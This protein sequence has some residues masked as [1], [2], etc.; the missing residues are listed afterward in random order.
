MFKK[1][2]LLR[3]LRLSG[4]SI[5]LVIDVDGVL[6]DG[7][8]WY[9]AKGKEYKRF[10]PHD[11]EALSVLKKHFPINII[12]ADIRGKKIS[13]RRLNDLGFDLQIIT[14]ESRQS[15]ISSIQAEGRNVLFVADSLSDIPAIT[16]ATFAVCP[17]NACIGVSRYVDYVLRT[18]G[19]R[20]VV[21]EIQQLFEEALKKGFVS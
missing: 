19:G 7:T 14:A 6:T 16:E 5:T 10:A 12:S 17:S 4:D 20:G 13:E 15:L 8:F 21:A 18:Q 9:S 11:A 1:I 3:R 2:K